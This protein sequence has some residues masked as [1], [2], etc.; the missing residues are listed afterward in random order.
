VDDISQGRYGKNTDP[1]DTSD[2][3]VT[4]YILRSL[5]SIKSTR[6]IELLAATTIYLEREKLEVH[7]PPYNDMSLTHL[8]EPI[9]SFE[10]SGEGGHI[11]TY[12]H[13]YINI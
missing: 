8:I 7:Y 11:Y 13:M 2:P 6:Y 4:E 9:D 3:G 5:C 1:A 12:T 10:K